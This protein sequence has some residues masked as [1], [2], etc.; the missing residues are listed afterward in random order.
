[1][2]L[3][4]THIYRYPVKGLSSNPLEQTSVAAGEGLPHDR[5]FAITHGETRFDPASPEWLP[6]TRFLMLMRNARLALLDSRFDPE[7]GRLTILLPGEPGVEADIT[8]ETGRRLAEEF[9]ST[10]LHGELRGNPRIIEAP[11][12]MFSDHR[13]KVVSIIGL[14]SLRDLE[15]VVRAPVDH[16][17]FRANFYFEGSD[18]WQ[19]FTWLG[20][21]IA[22]GTAR[23]RVTRR[24]DRCAAVNVNPGTGERDLDILPSLKQSFGHVDTGVYAE[25][26]SGGEIRLGDEI[27]PLP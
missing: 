6:K 27:R 3:K 7:S 16:R 8:S 20:K 17:R 2:T 19:E 13:S 5:R 25:V 14:A 24:I 10:F 1:M 22:L 12:H 9:L 18:P 26:V 21:E 4:L 11:G 23:L 15:R